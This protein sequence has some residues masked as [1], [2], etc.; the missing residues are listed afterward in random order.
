MSKIFELNINFTRQVGL[1]DFDKVGCLISVE[2]GEN[3]ESELDKHAATIYN[4]MAK[5]NP[6]LLGE[7][8]VTIDKKQV[9]DKAKIEPDIVVLKQYSNAEKNGDIETMDKLKLTYNI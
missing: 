6:N 1:S 3:I 9:I 2:D 5:R 7:G 4:W 8:I